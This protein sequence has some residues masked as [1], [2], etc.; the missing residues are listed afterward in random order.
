MLT[1]SAQATI[2]ILILTQC[3]L[4][5]ARSDAD[6][7][8]LE[9]HHNHNHNTLARTETT[10][11]DMSVD[12]L[13]NNTNPQCVN[14]RLPQ[15]A[16]ILHALCARMPHMA[17]CTMANL[18]DHDSHLL[19]SNNV[20]CTRFS[21][22]KDVCVQMPGMGNCSQFNALC[23]PGSVVNECKT[24]MIVLPSEMQL[25]TLISGICTDMAMD[26][27]TT[28]GLSDKRQDV[29]DCDL[30]TVY[31]KL[32]QS[33]PDMS[34]CGTWSALCDKLGD[35][36]PICGGG[37]D[38]DSA[39]I[40]RMYFHNSLEDYVLFKSWVPRNYLEYFA[41]LIVIMLAGIFY[42]GLKTARI[43]FEERFQLP[44]PGAD[45]GGMPHNIHVQDGHHAHLQEIGGW[46]FTWVP[47]RWHVDITRAVFSFSEVGLGLILMLVAMTFN[48]GMF[49]AVCVGALLGS[50]IF[51]RFAAA[52]KPPTHTGLCH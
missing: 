16:A 47:F 10:E 13:K 20:Y 51:G 34:Q 27:C 3:V 17:A 25:S 18:C 6:P 9:E 4:T 42:E 19:H 40:M 1:L 29:L 24:K 5:F 12:C 33:M 44:K 49:L 41:T 43:I 39:P 28:C 50:V 21:L 2:A 11:S 23:S 31:S 46:T 37:G 52:Y 35:D 30:L 32:C 7:K 8:P 38:G 36:W 15:T 22:I 14:Y 48:V 45:H 26:D